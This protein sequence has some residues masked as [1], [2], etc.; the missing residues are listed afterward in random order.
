M[1]GEFLTWPGK[2]YL[3]SR[4]YKGAERLC[5]KAQ[6]IHTTAEGTALLSQIRAQAA[7]PTPRASTSSAEPSASTSGLKQRKEKATTPAPEQKRDYTPDQ[8]AHVKRIRSCKATSYYEILNIEKTCSD[9]EIKKAYRKHSLAVH[10]DKNGAPG[11]D[12]AFK[13]Q[14]YLFGSGSR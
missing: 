8:L 12:E 7:N 13:C 14:S 6:K 11:S 1:H 4:D 3:A 5:L 2:Q 9:V 10:P